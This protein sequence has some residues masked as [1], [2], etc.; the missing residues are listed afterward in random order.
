[1]GFPAFHSREYYGSSVNGYQLLPFR[2]DRR[3]NGDYLLT[4][5]VGE[6][7]I[8]A[9]KQFHAFV[10]HQSS[11]DDP[12]YLDL[13]SKHFLADTES[14]AHMELLAAK[15]RTK[16]SFLDDFTKLHIFVTSLRCNQSCPYCQVSRQ[17]Q[18]ADR[19]LF[20]MSPQVLRRSVE[21]ML[22]S[23]AAHITMEFQGGEPLVNFDLVKDAIH[24]TKLLNVQ[25]G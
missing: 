10:S 16:K 6:Y 12:F 9:P 24:L 20:D 13:K 8:L 5:E 19:G 22:S 7:I 25:I 3:S 14:S 21:L 17:G 11:P 2:F 1:M 18:D 23:P 15:Y 4:N